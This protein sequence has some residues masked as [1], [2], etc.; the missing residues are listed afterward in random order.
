MDPLD[1]F[2]KIRRLAARASHEFEDAEP[3]ELLRQRVEEFIV[4]ENFW[5]AEES[6]KKLTEIMVLVGVLIIYNGVLW[7]E[8]VYPYLAELEKRSDSGKALFEAIKE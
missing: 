5:S 8:M 4:N 3:A 1:L 2:G 6:G 7:Q